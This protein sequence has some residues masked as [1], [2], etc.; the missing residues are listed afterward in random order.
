MK[1]NNNIYLEYIDANL[2]RLLALYDNNAASK[3]Y[4]MGDRF[5]WSWKLID[6]ANG[7]F[8]GASN[9]LARLLI[10]GLLPVNISETSILKR[11]DSMFRAAARL[12][13]RNGSMEEAF[14][15]ESSF[16]V[17]ALVAYDLLTAVEFWIIELE[18]IYARN[19]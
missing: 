9:G 4:G 17:T 1:S 16:C 11:I 18:I 15:Y 10:H 14:P 2:P 19:I 13:R 12:C 6:F 3:T 5:F 7:T 8:Q